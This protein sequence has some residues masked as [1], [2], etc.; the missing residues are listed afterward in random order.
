[1]SKGAISSEGSSGENVQHFSHL[2]MRINGIS[3]FRAAIRS[4]DYLKDKELVAIPV[5]T[6]N[7]IQSVRLV[8]FVEQRACLE[9][10][11]LTINEYVRI[12]RIIVYAKEIY[13]S[14]PGA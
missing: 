13:T 5:Q 3:T 12:N 9:F 14:H 1:M 2:R 4:I 11:H 8:N 6:R 10:A 7:R